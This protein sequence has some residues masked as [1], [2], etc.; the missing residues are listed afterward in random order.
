[1]RVVH[2]A[3]TLKGGPATHLSQLLPLQA[4]AY[5]S[6]TVFCPERHRHLIESEQVK[7]VSF[8]DTKRTMRGLASLYRY[9]REH[10][11]QHSYDIIHLHSSFA[12]LVGRSF[13]GRSGAPIVYCARGWSFAMDCSPARKLAYGLVE[14]ILA[15]NAE[16]VINIS[17]NEAAL[18][19]A[20][21]IPRQKCWTV[22]NGIADADW[23]PL[24]LGGRQPRKLLFVGRYDQQKG[25]DLLISAMKTLSGHGFE[26]ETIGGHVIGNPSVTSFPAGVHD[27]GWYD[28]ER[29][30]RAMDAADAVVIPSRWEGFGFVAAE[31]M[32]AGRPVL[33]SRVG[34]LAEIVVDG[35][36]GLLFEPNSVDAIVQA[37]LR[38]RGMDACQLGLEGR[39]RFETMF[40]AERMFHQID[41]IYRTLRSDLVFAAPRSMQAGA[42]AF[43][44]AD[45]G[46]PG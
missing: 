4:N 40:R 26:L 1:M 17:H 8:P 23:S 41:D 28:A 24:S 15:G 16:A 33:A 43:G 46:I 12:G 20:M 6:V 27:H 5:E 25:I 44:V 30:R 2:F 38:L 19:D 35:E 39:K 36:T 7:V 22:H 3:E 31:A 11:A 29:V 34:G 14:R 42:A 9:W 13:L 32:R 37:A 18:A 10:L 45:P 21:K